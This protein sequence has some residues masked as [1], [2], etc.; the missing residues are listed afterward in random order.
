MPRTTSVCP[1]YVALGMG[2]SRSYTHTALSSMAATSSLFT[3]STYSACTLPPVYANWCSLVPSVPHSRSMSSSAAV[4][5]TPR[6]PTHRTCVTSGT[7]LAAFL[8]VSSTS[9]LVAVGRLGMSERVSH[10][11]LVLRALDPPSSSSLSAASW[12]A[13]F[14]TSL[15]LTADGRFTSHTLTLLPMPHVA[16]SSRSGQYSRHWMGV[17]CAP[18]TTATVFMV[19]RSQMRSERSNDTDA[20]RLFLSSASPVTRASWSVIDVGSGTSLKVG[21]WP[22]R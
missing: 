18:G 5:H 9:G 4:A 11:M 12:S 7:S 22:L 13:W 20:S 10:I 19:V 15:G 21:I 14:S 6:Y 17:S 2:S 3:L 16:S 8:I 1:L